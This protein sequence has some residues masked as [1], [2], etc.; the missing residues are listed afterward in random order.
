MQCDT[1]R[2]P[3]PIAPVGVRAVKGA[4]VVEDTPP[5]A[6]TSMRAI[7]GMAPAPFRGFTHLG[8][9]VVGGRGTAPRA[10]RRPQRC[11]PNTYSTVPPTALVASRGD[12]ATAHLGRNHPL[13][14]AVVLVKGERAGPGRLPQHVV[15]VDPRAPGQPRSR[16]HHRPIRGWRTARATNRVRLPGVANLARQVGGVPVFP[17]SSTRPGRGR[18]R[19]PPER[20][21]RSAR[22]GVPPPR[23]R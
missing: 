2:A 10:G 12:P 19:T 3:M 13:L 5:P 8:L 4:P 16:A 20:A 7:S 14:V 9:V 21:A 6:G 11:E 22:R 1:K 17:P 23:A 15:L 18:S